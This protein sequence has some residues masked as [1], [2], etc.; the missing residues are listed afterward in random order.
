MKTYRVLVVV[1]CSLVAWFAYLALFA[2]KKPGAEITKEMW[3][4]NTVERWRTNTVEVWRT[5]TVGGERT[6]TVVQ[7]VTNQVIKEVPASLSASERQVAALGYKYSHAPSVIDGS[8]T[9]YKASPVAVDVHIDESAATFLKENTDAVK[10]SV[11]L[12]LR[13]RSILVAEKSPCH[14]KVNIAGTWR[15][16]VPRVA[17]LTLRLELRQNVALQ[18]QGDIIECGGIVWSTETSKLV[19]TFNTTEE[20]KTC[21]QEPVDKFCN[22]YLKAREREKEVGSRIPALPQDFLSGGK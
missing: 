16:D 17:I 9:L 6:N 8:D 12:S 22:D 7:T 13:S 3:Y 4:T 20:L 5:N 14:L 2:A 21:L 11:E 19:R 18:R 10:N 15:T 1:L